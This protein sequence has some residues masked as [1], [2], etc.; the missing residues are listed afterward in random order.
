MA[1]IE[2]IKFPQRLLSVDELA[3]PGIE[4]P[5]W[6]NVSR[7]VGDNVRNVKRTDTLWVQFVIDT[8][9]SSAGMLRI[10][11]S[12][13]IDGVYG[14]DTKAW[15]RHFQS[16]PGAQELAQGDGAF[17]PVRPDGAV[18]RVPAGEF[19]KRKAF[20]AYR[21]NKAMATVAPLFFFQL[22]ASA[23]NDR[24]LEAFIKANS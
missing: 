9:F 19:S 24:T 8:I 20:S 22:T 11:R 1:F 4:L 14:D 5:R 2:S 21:L 3:D 17:I 10:V 7:D 23:A 12:L 18:F 15:I 6:V 13:K 16:D